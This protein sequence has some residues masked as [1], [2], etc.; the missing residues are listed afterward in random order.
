MKDSSDNHIYE[1]V[2]KDRSI[3]QKE[4]IDNVAPYIVMKAMMQTSHLDLDTRTRIVKE[5][6]EQFP[7]TK[8][9]LKDW[10]DYVSK[11]F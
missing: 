1:L 5:L 2:Q 3:D 6:L 11:L 7:Q 9:P 4:G 10:S 8:R